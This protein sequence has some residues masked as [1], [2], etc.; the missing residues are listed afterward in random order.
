MR[1]EA[2]ITGQERE[3]VRESKRERAQERAR[4][5]EREREH[6]VD[7]KRRGERKKK[8]R[9]CGGG[10]IVRERERGHTLASY[11]ERRASGKGT[12]NTLN[13]HHA[14]PGAAAG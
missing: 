2:S 4:E 10:Y 7:G 13:P 14:F 3:S 8:R 12:R 1:R 11:V 6:I 5:K 9:M